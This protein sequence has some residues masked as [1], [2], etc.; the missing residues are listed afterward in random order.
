MKSI[1]SCQASLV[2]GGARSEVQAIS[3]L[4]VQPAL[5]PNTCQGITLKCFSTTSHTQQRP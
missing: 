2:P 3:P 1:Q 4:H 5:L